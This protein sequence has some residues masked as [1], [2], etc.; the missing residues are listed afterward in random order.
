MYSGRCTV[1]DKLR[2]VI[3]YFI[4]FVFIIMSFGM[5]IF[6]WYG[7][8]LPSEEVLL[9][10][11]PPSTTKIY[12]SS[13]DL[14]DEYAFERRVIVPFKNIPDLIKGAFIAA[15]DREFYNHS[16]I[17]IQSLFR[18]II[19]NT[20]KKS[21]NSKPAGGSTIT[22]QV[23]KN[24]LVGNERSLTRK[25]KEAIMAIRTE[26]TISKDKILEIYLNHLY[27]GKGCYGIVE[28]CHYYFGKNIDDISPSEAA[29]I[30]SLPSAPSVYIN[31]KDNSKVILKRNSVL[32]QMYEMGYIDQMTLKKSLKEEVNLKFKR[33][34]MMSPYFSEEI[35]RI[36]SRNISEEDFFKGGYIITTTMNTKI[37]NIA[38]KSLEDGLIECEKRKNWKGTIYYNI[39]ENQKDIRDKLIEI[40]H[41]LPQ[42]INIIKPVIIKRILNNT[43]ESYDKDNKKINIKIDKNIYPNHNIEINDVILCR[44][45]DRR[46]VYEIY[47]H[48]SMTGSIVVLDPENGDVLGMCGGY[49]FDINTFNCA[50]QAKRQPGSIIKPF[51]YLG[52]LES[53]MDEYDIIEDKNVSIKLGSGEIYSP[54]N[55]NNKVYG[56]TYLRDGLI[57]S[58]NLA[59]INLVLEVGFQN[60]E[61]FL[62]RFPMI[63]GKVR[64]S[65]VLGANETTLMDVVSS[66]SGILNGGKIVVPRFIKKIDM[67]SREKVINY[68]TIDFLCKIKTKKVCNPENALTMKN[69]LR[70]TVK[71][72]TANRLSK[73][74]DELK[75]DIGGKTGTTNDFKDAWF[76]GYMTKGKKTFIIGVFV[77][78]MK[79]MS[80]GQGSTGS[81]IAMPIFS[82]FVES[83]CKS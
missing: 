7:R 34:K 80:L 71:Y 45:D 32:Y 15:E 19:E 56:K 4:S 68:N 12:S 70:D 53:G 3:F 1:L 61:K 31:L 64:F 72:G 25:I 37:Q 59:T 75:I 60:I 18:A 8:A 22:Q 57:Y 16:G 29:F 26:Y 28:A 13:G 35:H 58:R 23:A 78:Y 27:L 65:T 21:W 74:F 11:F 47:Q 2:K 6:F 40:E 39:S 48:P 54:K 76:V 52:A 5:A 81:K 73:L 82:N 43:Y 42:T 41:N 14:M 83:Y 46:K 10:Y 49:S 36:F 63:S 9:S 67:Q 17:S 62:R 77:G 44:Y 20:A 24:L 50:T 69:I 51:V 38:Q 66:F 30:A 79:P 33:E 55:Y